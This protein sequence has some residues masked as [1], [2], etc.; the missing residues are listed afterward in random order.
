[1]VRDPEV[2]LTC[3]QVEALFKTLARWRAGEEPLERNWCLTI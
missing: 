1:M 3:Q 2:D